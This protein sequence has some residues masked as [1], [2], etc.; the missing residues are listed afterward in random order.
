MLSG[1]L[2]SRHADFSNICTT[3]TH[4]VGGGGAGYQG[5]APAHFSPHSF[6]ARKKNG[7]CVITWFFPTLCPAA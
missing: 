1:A 5:L 2:F 6:F 3:N 4:L 7:C